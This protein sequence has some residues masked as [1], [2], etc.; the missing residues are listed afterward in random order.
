MKENAPTSIRPHEDLPSKQMLRLHLPTNE[1]SMSS[2]FKKCTVE[3]LKN[4][5]IPNILTDSCSAKDIATDNFVVRTRA[6]CVKSAILGTRDR[7]RV[8]LISI[9]F[10]PFFV[11]LSDKIDQCFVF[12]SFCSLYAHLP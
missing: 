8:R 9:C 1:H 6:G 7:L 11:V 12:I 10:H 5:L 4:P 3:C 2:K